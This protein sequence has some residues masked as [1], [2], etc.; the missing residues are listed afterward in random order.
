MLADGPV[1][2]TIEWSAYHPRRACWFH[3][4]PNYLAQGYKGDSEYISMNGT[5]RDVIT[6]GVG[7]YATTLP[8][9]T[10]TPSTVIERGA[11]VHAYQTTVRYRLLKRNAHMIVLYADAF[12]PRD[13]TPGAEGAALELRINARREVE[14]HSLTGATIF[15]ASSQPHVAQMQSVEF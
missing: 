15:G 7:V 8:Q 5:A 3:N 1:H 6:Q 4:A 12:G 11:R 13:L 14:K 2:Q 9:P 10:A